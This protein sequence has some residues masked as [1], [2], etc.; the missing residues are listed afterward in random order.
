MNILFNILGVS[1]WLFFMFWF[2]RVT[3]PTKFV[4]MCRFKSNDQALDKWRD[5]YDPI[6]LDIKIGSHFNQS[7]RGSHE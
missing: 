1:A 2:W 3:R 6:P 4:D 5:E 7:L